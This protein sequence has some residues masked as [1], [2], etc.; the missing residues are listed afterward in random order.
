MHS[1][2]FCLPVCGVNI[3]K[4]APDG[5]CPKHCLMLRVYDSSMRIVAVNFDTVF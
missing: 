5:C 4:G 3:M 2:F 1:F